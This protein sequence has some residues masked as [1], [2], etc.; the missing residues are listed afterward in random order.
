MQCMENT[1]LCYIIILGVC[2]D[3]SRKVYSLSKKK[4]LGFFLSM[5]L[6]PVVVTHLVAGEWTQHP[7]LFS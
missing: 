1:Y 6:P 3:S 5:G 4:K 2:V 7:L